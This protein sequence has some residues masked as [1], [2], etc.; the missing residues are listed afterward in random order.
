MGGVE[1]DLGS[2]LIPGALRLIGAGARAAR[3]R[4]F[5]PSGVFDAT[6][7]YQSPRVDRPRDY[8]FDVPV[9][10]DGAAQDL[11]LHELLGYGSDL[12]ITSAHKF[13]CSTTGGI[14]AGRK[15]LVDAVYLQSRGLERV[16]ADR[17]QVRGFFE[18]AIRKLPDQSLAGPV[19]DRVNAKYVAAQAEG[20]V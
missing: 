7:R 2:P 20:R 6:F 17:L 5:L 19:R 11:R 16:A 15:D 10:V 14:V 4:S 12:V 8:E 3:Y 9:I 13:L 1:G 18:E